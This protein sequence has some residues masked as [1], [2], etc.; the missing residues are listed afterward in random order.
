MQSVTQLAL[1]YGTMTKPFCILVGAMGEARYQLFVR[2]LEYRAKHRKALD[3]DE[4]SFLFAG[5]NVLLGGAGGFGREG[6]RKGSLGRI[7]SSW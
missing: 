1:S 5:E 3:L 6:D 2:L 4:D 7:C